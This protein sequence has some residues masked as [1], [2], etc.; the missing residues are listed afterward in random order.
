VALDVQTG[1]R[2]WHYQLVHH[3]VWDFDNPA[4]PILLD[5]EVDGEQIPALAQITKQG[6]VYVFNRVTGEPVWPIEERPV[7]TDTNVP[8]ERL[9]PTQPV[10]SRP[11]AYTRQGFTEND[12]IDFTPELRRKAL[13][14]IQNVRFGPIFTPIVL[15]DPENGYRGTITFPRS[16]GGANWESGAVDSDNGILYVSTQLSAAIEGLIPTANDMTVDYTMMPA[17]TLSVDGLPAI[18]PPYGQISAIDLKRGEMLWQIP[19]ADTPEEIANHPALA[20]IELGRTGRP[21]R[22][23]LLVTRSLLFSGEGVG[24]KPVFRA[25]DKMTGEILAEI[26]IPATQT[27]LPMSYM[28]DG[29]QYIVFAIGALGNPA[30]LIALRL[31]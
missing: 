29:V 27:G 8:G 30:E 6:W 13:T 21:N 20:G 14:L 15:S 11:P 24:G 7:P 31:P 23:G 19:N 5:I 9:S 3:D 10:P 4:A 17:E 26:D 12:L 18:K 28:V 2:L 25:H 22:V 16:T 1:G